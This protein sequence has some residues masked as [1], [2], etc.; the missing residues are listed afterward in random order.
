M[1][2]GDISSVS[3]AAHTSIRPRG[4]GSPAISFHNKFIDEEC[5]KSSLAPWERGGVRAQYSKSF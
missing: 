4:E 3:Y 1:E 2:A 5:S